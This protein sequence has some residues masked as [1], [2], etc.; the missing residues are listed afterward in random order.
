MTMVFDFDSVKLVAA[1]SNRGDG[2]MSL[3]YGNT[4][5]TLDN[6]KNFLGA[7]G[8]NYE[9]LVCAKQTHSGNVACV[10]KSQRGGGAVFYD[11]ALDDCDALITADRNLPLAVFTADC[12]S[13]F[14][15]DPATPA[16]GMVHAG[17][18]SSLANITS[19]AVQLMRKKFWS[20]PGLLRAGFGP[21]IKKCCFEIDGDVRGKFTTGVVERGGRTYLDLWEVN[22]KQLLDEGVLPVNISPAAE[23]TFCSGDDFF[24]FRKEKNVS[25]RMISVI[26]LK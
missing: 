17:W 14:L 6:R 19:S 13:V 7:I 22:S 9:S 5:H 26:M 2:N 1:F 16:I 18:R 3:C 24:S 4:S 11:T 23:C 12:L 8:I 15:Y 25:G 21:S 10:N 20:K